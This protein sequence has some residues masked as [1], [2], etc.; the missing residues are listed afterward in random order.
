[1][2]RLTLVVF[3]LVLLF[4]SSVALLSEAVISSII[5]MNYLLGSSYIDSAIA[6]GIGEVEGLLAQRGS[7]SNELTNYLQSINGPGVS[8]TPKTDLYEE[9]QGVNAEEFGEP[10]D[11]R[12]RRQASESENKNGD[13]VLLNP[14]ADEI[15]LPHEKNFE[16]LQDEIFDSIGTIAHDVAS[17]LGMHLGLRPHTLEAVLTHEED[18]PSFPEVMETVAR[19]FHAPKI[20]LAGLHALIERRDYYEDYYD[21]ENLLQNRGDLK[22]NLLIK[23]VPNENKA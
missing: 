5:L 9:L 11:L 20:L 23:A 18:A 8:D 14:Q 4:G 17:E 12:R 6:A 15:N 2:A 22:P 19:R 21:L 13:E 10:Q 3:S 7:I 16:E 1:M